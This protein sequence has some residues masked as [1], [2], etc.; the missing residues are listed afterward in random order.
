MDI[1]ARQK[2]F[3][4]KLLDL[5]R[6]AQQPIHYS[7]VAERLGVNPF[8]AYDMM[9]LL[10]RK[11]LV[12][13]E[14]RLAPD[15]SGP[16]RSTIA[17]VPTSKARA[18]LRLLGGQSIDDAEWETAKQRILQNL[19]TRGDQEFLHEL[20]EN[21]PDNSPP[22]IF[23]TEVITALLLQLQQVRTRASESNVARLLP[24]LRALIPSGRLGLGMV[25]GLSIGSLLSQRPERPSPVDRLLGQIGRY[26]RCL[27]TLNEEHIGNLSDFLQE[28]LLSIESA[29]QQ[30]GLD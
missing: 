13:A 10:E 7:V 19:R 9:K 17:F 18:A 14:Y 20:L 21:L 12:R 3:L 1:T 29:A 28:A 27:S 24:D 30:T 26:Q 22:L 16:G 11:K 25:A 6:E 5:Y 15:H 4:D 8:S 23:C 2:E